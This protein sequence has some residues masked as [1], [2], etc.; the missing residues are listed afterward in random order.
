MG[1]IV[2]AM[3]EGNGEDHLLASGTVAVEV[4]DCDGLNVA[5]GYTGGAAGTI[6][7]VFEIITGIDR[8]RCVIAGIIEGAAQEDQ[9]LCAAAFTVNGYGFYRQPLPDII[10]IVV[11][12]VCPA[13]RFD[14]LVCG[15]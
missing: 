15:L 5:V 2:I 1:L 13:V 6:I 4:A 8:H 12:A 11:T 14:C 3:L 9:L 10:G 7:G